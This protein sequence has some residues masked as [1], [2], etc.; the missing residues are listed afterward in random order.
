MVAHVARRGRAEQ[1]V[2]HRVDQA[3]TVR[4]SLE[5]KV[6]GNRHAPEHQGPAGGETV[7]IEART[8]AV[9]HARTPARGAASR[10]SAQARSSGVVILRFRAEPGTTA[11]G[12]PI[13][14]SATA[15]SVTVTRSRKASS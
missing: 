11:T 10:S 9:A 1:R 13:R 2:A 5:A 6:G 7:G 12:A 8:H 14:S 4:V 3:V 15:S